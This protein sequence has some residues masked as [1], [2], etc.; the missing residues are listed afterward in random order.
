[1][2]TISHG[3][4]KKHTTLTEG[5][6]LR[7][8]WW[9]W[10]ALLSI[11]GFV[12]MGVVYSLNFGDQPVRPQVGGTWFVVNMVFLLIGI[13]AAFFLRT[14]LWRN[15]YEGQRVPPV[16]YLVGAMIPW[17]VLEIGGLLS[18]AGV[19]YARSF[20]P[21]IIP[22]IVAFAFFITMFPKGTAML[23][24]TGDSQDPEIYEEPR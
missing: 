18:L 16:N 21:N 2:T 17:I 22:A 13:P 10:F 23:R 11:P 5:A 12:F 9:I 1:M 4:D 3:N 15:Y 14:R 19:W 20:T 24:P 7:Y 6:A 8:A